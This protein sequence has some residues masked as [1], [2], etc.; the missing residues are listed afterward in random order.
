M[1]ATSTT[2][3]ARSSRMMVLNNEARAVARGESMEA[4]ADPLAAS[5]HRRR[6]LLC[7]EVRRVERAETRRLLEALH[8]EAVPHA[9]A[10][11]TPPASRHTV[12]QA[13]VVE[14]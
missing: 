2:P 9:G 8:G 10:E 11:V 7:P 12:A 13:E 14:M 5:Q 4:A 1:C 3:F 6:R